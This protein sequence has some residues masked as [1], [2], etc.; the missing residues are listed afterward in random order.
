MTTTIL[1]NATDTY[2]SEKYP[3]S[4]GS[5]SPRLYVTGSGSTDSRYAF[6]FFSLPFPRGCKI[7]SAKFRVWNAQAWP[8]AVTLG[9]Q[10]VVA[11]WSATK[12]T[13]GHQPGVT[14]AAANVTKTRAAVNTMW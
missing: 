14:G 9:L 3:T 13:W 5:N 12:I 8:G 11:S 6:L 7:Q 1:R 4:N 10:R 2:V